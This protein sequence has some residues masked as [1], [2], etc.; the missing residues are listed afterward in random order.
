MLIAQHTH[1]AKCIVPT[2]NTINN[3]RIFTNIISHLKLIFTH[4][5]AFCCISQTV[6]VSHYFPVPGPCLV[7]CH[8]HFATFCFPLSLHFTTLIFTLFCTSCFTTCC[9]HFTVFTPNSWHLDPLC[10]RF[11]PYSSN[12]LISFH[13]LS[14]IFQ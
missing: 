1:T 10:S 2:Y 3:K 8:S 4:F 5:A 13:H 12:F 7:S 14:R 9:L 11:L 6:S